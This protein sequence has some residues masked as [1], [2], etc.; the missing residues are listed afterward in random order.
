MLNHYVVPAGAILN[1][2]HAQNIGG[3]H[4]P[5]DDC[6]G[7]KDTEVWIKRAGYADYWPDA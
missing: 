1:F 4:R 5:G 2:F 7:C 3:N 6:P